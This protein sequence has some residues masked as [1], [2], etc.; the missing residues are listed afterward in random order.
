MV[1]GYFNELRQVI[2]NLLSNSKDAIERQMQGEEDTDW[3]I[4]IKLKQNKNQ[5]TLL[6]SDNGGGIPSDII[7]EVFMPY[8]TTKFADQG[9][10]IGLYLSK[11]IIEKVHN[12]RISVSS[13]KNKTH[14]KILLD[15]TKEDDKNI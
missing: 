8:F 13:R 5:I 3:K 6:I 9:T 4:K 1:F 11:I 2:L 12:G 7:N 15:T 14:F 10:G